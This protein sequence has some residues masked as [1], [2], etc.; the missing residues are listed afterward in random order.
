VGGGGPDTKSKESKRKSVKNSDIKVQFDDQALTGAK[1][2]IN[3]Y[4]EAIERSDESE[5][6]DINDRS[7]NQILLEGGEEEF[8]GGE[9]AIN[10]PK[11]ENGSCS[12]IG[13]SGTKPVKDY[14]GQVIYLNTVEDIASFGSCDED[15]E[16]D[17]E[18]QTL[19]EHYKRLDELMLKKNK[20]LLNETTSVAGEV[21]VLDIREKSE[22]K[23]EFINQV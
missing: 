2:R 17:H 4:I 21:T 23:T 19:I 20:L 16:L 15:Y 13:S 7:N 3:N 6:I 8:V 11:T 22:I 14:P 9:G 1:L 18:E 12:L 5:S 10:M